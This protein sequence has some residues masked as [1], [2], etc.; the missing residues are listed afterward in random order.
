MA[1]PEGALRQEIKQNRPFPSRLQEAVLG[2]LK[3]AA[4]LRWQIAQVLKDSGLSME[5]YN[6][7]RILR[8]AGQ[9]GLPTLEVA[10]RMIERSPAITRMIDKLEVKGLVRRLRCHRDRRRVY[11]VITDA[12]LALLAPLDAPVESLS[13]SMVGHLDA[14]EIESVIS[15]L[16]RLRAGLR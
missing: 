2:I 1:H 7:L 9:D 6:V 14:T 11:C 3:T 4:D 10:E 16:D 15:I 13:A 5:Q 12:G 8:G